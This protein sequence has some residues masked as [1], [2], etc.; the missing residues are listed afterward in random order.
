VVVSVS[1][2]RA[3]SNAMPDASA[4]APADAATIADA[5]EAPLAI[6]SADAV[7]SDAPRASARS[8][9]LRCPAAPKGSTRVYR[10]CNSSV[11]CEREGGHCELA[12]GTPKDRHPVSLC[13]DDDC[14][15]DQDCTAGK[16]CACGTYDSKHPYDH[17]R[18]IWGNCTS[19]AD[20][21]GH[22]CAEAVG[23]NLASAPDGPSRTR[24]VFGRY[25]HSNLDR[26]LRDADCG[27]KKCLF[28]GGAF[29]CASPP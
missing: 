3:P 5:R 8:S 4:A 28:T 22:T 11:V 29:R 18:C 24:G 12:S 21:G 19:D 13:R 25:C 27:A 17:N 26:C 2:C 1:G 10:H 23:L 20:C 7:S 15:K 16:V 9:S 14:T 6:A